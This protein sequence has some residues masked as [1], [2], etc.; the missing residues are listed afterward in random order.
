MPQTTEGE[1]FELTNDYITVIENYNTVNDEIKGGNLQLRSQFSPPQGHRIDGYI[2]LTHP[3]LNQ[4]ADLAFYQTYIED[5]YDQRLGDVNQDGTINILDVVTVANDILSDGA[6]LTGE[7]FTLADMNSDGTI[8]VLD[9]VA[10]MNI[11]LES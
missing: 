9:L 11:I 1:H 4:S 5:P 2:R 7:A 8:T 6:N 3:D 10:I